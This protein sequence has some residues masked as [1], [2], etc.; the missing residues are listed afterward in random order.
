MAA[1][2]I[3]LHGACSRF[4]GERQSNA[5]PFDWNKDGAVLPVQ[6]GVFESGSSFFCS[7]F[8]GIWQTSKVR[9]DSFSGA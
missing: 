9:G 7:A 2:G 5:G 3:G 4:E 8:A 6:K 1:I